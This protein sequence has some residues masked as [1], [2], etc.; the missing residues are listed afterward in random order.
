MRDRPMRSE[1]KM[2]DLATTDSP[3]RVIRWMVAVGQPVRR[4]QPLLEIE[5]DKATM[6]VEATVT[7]LLAEV[8]IAPGDTAGAGDVIARFGVEEGAT[9]TARDARAVVAP[10][11]A[12]QA[13]PASRTAPA[14]GGGGMFA[15]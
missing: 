12:P 2:P 1:M 15:R 13:A 4:G 9:T 10:A 8:L 3:I 5:T 6:D 14:P 11:T 7:G